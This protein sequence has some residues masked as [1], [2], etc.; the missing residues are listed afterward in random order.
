MTGIYDTALTIG[1]LAVI[2]TAIMAI[3]RGGAWLD[4][5]I[6]KVVSPTAIKVVALELEIDDIERALNA[7]R[8]EVA[9]TYVTSRT[10]ERIEARI[11]E[12]FKAQREENGELRRLLL[13][14]I[15]AKT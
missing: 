7:F 10:M 11:E 13:Q 4:T 3:V 9:N 1:W 5:R 12:G 6:G 15:A 2:G 8:L 14:V